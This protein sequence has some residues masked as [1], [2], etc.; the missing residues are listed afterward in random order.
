MK[1]TF[2]LYFKN[3]IHAK[4]FMLSLPYTFI[5]ENESYITTSDYKVELNKKYLEVSSFM[6]ERQFK[7]RFPRTPNSYILNPNT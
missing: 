3:A 7:Q 1:F 5:A 6:S 2:N 4:L